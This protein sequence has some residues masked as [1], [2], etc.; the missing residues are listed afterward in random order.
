MNYE[1]SNFSVFQS[2]FEDTVKQQ[3]VA[4]PSAS[5]V[6]ESHISRSTKIGM[7]LGIIAFV[8]LGLLAIV[9]GLKK[10][11]NARRAERS[12]HSTKPTDS[13][14]QLDTPDN[15]A[16][17]EIAMNSLIDIYRE[18]PDRGKVELLDASAPT[19]SGHDISELSQPSLPIAHELMTHRSSDELS[20]TQYPGRKDKLAILVSTNISR[21]SRASTGPSTGL[22]RIETTISSQQTKEIN[23]D[24]SLPP[25]P[26]SESLQVSPV[27]ASFHN[28][29]ITGKGIITVLEGASITSSI[30]GSIGQTPTNTPIDVGEDDST[31]HG[32]PFWNYSSMEL[33]IVVPPGHSEAIVI[34]PLNIYKNDG[35]RRCNFF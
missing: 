8:F 3:L 25:T 27:V 4:I 2:K 17:Q 19:G 22:A 23:L 12:C 30:R 7:S 21:E 26:I 24:R 29:S 11:R 18:L 13:S 35:R 34:K 20:I 14:Q 1:Q 6:P 32:S 9:L 33:E 31:L 15:F 16:L 10:R 5:A 28:S